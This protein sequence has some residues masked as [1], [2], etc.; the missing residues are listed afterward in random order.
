M[1]KNLMNFLYMSFIKPLFQKTEI[2]KQP[3]L[4]YNID[5]LS[6]S[7]QK[8]S[9]QLYHCRQE[10]SLKLLLKVVDTAR[11]VQLLEVSR[12]P[13]TLDAFHHHMGRVKALTDLSHYLSSSLDPAVYAERKEKPQATAPKLLVR[14]GQRSS[15]V[16]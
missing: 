3:L 8:M 6:E 9:V 10:E 5:E 11:N 7:L 12:I 4:S 15:P 14:N 16:I 13:P 2:S 1:I